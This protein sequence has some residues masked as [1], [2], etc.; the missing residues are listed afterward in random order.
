RSPL[1]ILNN[2]WDNCDSCNSGYRKKTKIINFSGCDFGFLQ[3][4]SSLLFTEISLNRY[5]Y[6]IV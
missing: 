6:N 5:Y 2:W 3:N 4:H 1:L